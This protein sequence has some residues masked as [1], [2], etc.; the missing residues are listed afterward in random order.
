[1]LVIDTRRKQTY[2]PVVVEK[3]Y[4]IDQSIRLDVDIRVKDEMVSA[5]NAA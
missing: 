3:S 1:M 5:I 4:C 2:L